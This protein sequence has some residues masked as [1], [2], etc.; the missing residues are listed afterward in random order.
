MKFSLNCR[1]KRCERTHYRPQ[2]EVMDEETRYISRCLN[3]EQSP[4]C[5]RCRYHYSQNGKCCFGLRYEYNH[6]QC[7][8][9]LINGNC[10]ALT[11]Q[12]NGVQP[13]YPQPRVVYPTIRNVASPG[14]PVRVQVGGYPAPA[15]Y[16]NPHPT[17]Q[18]GPPQPGQ[19]LITLPPAQPAPIATPEQSAIKS[20][21]IHFGW[22]AMEGAFTFLLHWFQYRR[23][24]PM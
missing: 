4:D 12:A 14:Q 24:R 22:G 1:H 18:F 19:A 11:A 23:P 2:G 13:G 10:S 3:G 5:N 16:Y 17:P 21:A 15:P 7:K 6:P 9:C 8:D 20:A